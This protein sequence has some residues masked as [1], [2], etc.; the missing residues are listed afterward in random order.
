MEGLAHRPPL[1]YIIRPSRHWGKGSLRP[2][3]VSPSPSHAAVRSAWV[4]S[5]TLVCVLC[6]RHTLDT[7]RGLWYGPHA[8][9]TSRARQARAFFSRQAGRLTQE[10]IRAM[11]RMASTFFSWSEVRPHAAHVRAF[12]VG[13]YMGHGHGPWATP[14]GRRGS[15]YGTFHEPFTNLSRFSSMPTS[16][17]H[18]YFTKPFT[19]L[20]RNLPRRRGFCLRAT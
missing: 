18:K 15:P 19:N 20:P 7:G 2:Q 16:G 10:A 9:G 5:V 3:A 17:F 8:I 13:A 1:S 11:G 6:M 12:P 4:P 14:L